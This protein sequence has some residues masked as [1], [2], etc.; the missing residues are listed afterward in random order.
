[1]IS[2]IPSCRS[3]RSRYTNGKFELSCGSEIRVELTRVFEEPCKRREKVACVGLQMHVRRQSSEHFKY[4]R[5]GLRRCRIPGAIAGYC[6]LPKPALRWLRNEP[7]FREYLHQQLEERGY[8]LVNP[9]WPFSRP[10]IVV[11]LTIEQYERTE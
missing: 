7:G 10:W 3:L 1:M 9:W 4:L 5:E 8:Q 6:Y 11:P 2:S